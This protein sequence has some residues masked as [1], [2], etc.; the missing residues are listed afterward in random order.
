MIYQK[1]NFVT[2]NILLAC[3]STENAKRNLKKG[4]LLPLTPAGTVK[5]LQE[6]LEMEMSKN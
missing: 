4:D 3:K 1:K 6:V 2:L 5:K